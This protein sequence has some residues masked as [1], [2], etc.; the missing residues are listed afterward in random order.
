MKPHFQLTRL[1]CAF[2]VT[3][4]LAFGACLVLMALKGPNGPL[5]FLTL[6]A[7]LAAL[8]KLGKAYC[9]QAKTTALSAASPPSPGSQQ[10]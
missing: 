4:L 2:L 6:G 3:N 5:I 1:D 9:R 10:P 8:A 7:G